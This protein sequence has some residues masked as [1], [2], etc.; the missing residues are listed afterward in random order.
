MSWST[1][2]A[3]AQ[4]GMIEELDEAEVR[5]QFETN[6]FGAWWVTQAALPLLRA[7]GSGHILQVSSIGDI[8]AYASSRLAVEGFS[9]ALAQEVAA[10]GVKVTLIEP[11]AFAT[12]I[13]G[14]SARHATALPD[15]AEVR[16]AAAA[17]RG[18]RMPEVGSPTVAAAGH[19]HDRGRRRATAAGVPRRGAP[20]DR[21]RRVR[22]PDRH[23]EA[24]AAGRG[25]RPGQVSVRAVFRRRSARGVRVL[26]RD[27]GPSRHPGHG[28]AH[29][30]PVLEGRCLQVRRAS[31]QCR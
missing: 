1:T 14:S 2:R 27:G 24:L 4:L 12:D 21:D 13:N 7:Q 28:S 8:G 3:F 20:G 6:V 15:Y 25:S 29:D 26:A 19:P 11:G 31:K 16:E 30:A 10:F 22:V 5:D 23:V 17:L 9:Q 18:A